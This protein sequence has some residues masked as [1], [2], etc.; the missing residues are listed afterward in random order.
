MFL[1]SC[2]PATYTSA[3]GS[4]L[5]TGVVMNEMNHSEVAPPVAPIN[6]PHQNGDYIKFNDAL[7]IKPET[8][9]YIEFYTAG[10]IKE[11]EIY[12]KDGSMPKGQFIFG[13]DGNLY[14]KNEF[15]V[16]YMVAK[17]QSKTK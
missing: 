9:G 16:T 12:P 8:E 15:N 1:C 13:S 2:V 3:V 4:G 5:V 11:S 10:T 17:E 6:Y 14:Y 7:V